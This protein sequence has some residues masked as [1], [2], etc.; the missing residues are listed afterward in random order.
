[1]A[2]AQNGDGRFVRHADGYS[3]YGRVKVTVEPH[4][5]IHCYRF[6]WQAAGA[7]PL[8][9]MRGAC[10][11][12]IKRAL[13]EPLADGR[14]VAFIQVSIV[15]GRLHDRDTNE[16]SLGHAHFWPSATP[17]REQSCWMSELQ[18]RSE[19]W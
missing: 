2:A 1:V 17:C 3:E 19:E 13:A 7:L 18:C 9:F 15:D 16:H 8:P 14:R 4:P 10:L 6:V 5:G 12:G 11:E